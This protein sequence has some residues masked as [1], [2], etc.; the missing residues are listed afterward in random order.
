LLQR[1]LEKYELADLCLPLVSFLQPRH[2]LDNDAEAGV[3]LV[4]L[5]ISLVVVPVLAVW[6]I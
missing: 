6:V 3:G 5:E 1:T 2:S 4:N